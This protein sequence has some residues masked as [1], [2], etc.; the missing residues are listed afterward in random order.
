MLIRFIKRSKGNATV[1]K[2]YFT[3]TGYVNATTWGMI[4][5]DFCSVCATLYPGINVTVLADNLQV[6]HDE[7][8]LRQART[9]N[10]D[11]VF[12]PPNTSHF[13]QPLDDLIFA[14]FKDQL[15]RFAAQFSVALSFI[16]QKQKS[17]EIMSAAAAMAAEIALQPEVI[18]KA[19]ANTFI[20]PWDPEGLE[21]AARANVAITVRRKIDREVDPSSALREK[22]ASIMATEARRS[23]ALVAKAAALTTKVRVK[24]DYSKSFSTD[25]LLK[26]AEDSREAQAVAEAEKKAI[27]DAKQLKRKQREEAS[28]LITCRAPDCAEK[29]GVRKGKD[30]LWC[31]HCEEFTICAEHYETAANKDLMSAHEVECLHAENTDRKRARGEDD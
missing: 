27:T 10:V 25:A 29:W 1:V 12:L 31:E 26:S 11:F 6:H 17:S 5:A 3:E 19:F 9:K 8:T 23:A 28:L 13:L 2:Y 7:T 21:N 16:G 20:W 14:I 15:R 4:V 22:A 30:W 24:A 18:R